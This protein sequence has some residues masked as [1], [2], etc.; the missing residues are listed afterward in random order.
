M[1]SIRKEIVIASDVDT[2][3][4]AVRDFGA[5]DHMAAGFVTDCHL[6]GADR[7]V[8]FFTGTVL[9]ERL[10]TTDD[11]RRRL[12]WSIVDATYEHHTGAVE[13]F[14]EDG[15]AT[16]LVWTSDLLPEALEAVTDGM[17][18][19]GLAAIHATLSP[20]SAPAAA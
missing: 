2:V 10:I 17:M 1:A 18:D 14:A 4:E 16:R 13:L 12:V 15:G 8:T 5:L 6:D 3:W 20:D 11:V 19:Q 7:L 9:R